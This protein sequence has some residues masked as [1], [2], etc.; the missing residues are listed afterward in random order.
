MPPRFA[1]VDCN[2]FY[3]SCERLF[4]PRLIGRPIIVLS[5]NDGCVIARSNE[6]KTVGIG[7]GQPFHECADLIR[8]HDIAVFSANFTL[9]GDL[10]HRVMQTLERFSPFIEVYSIDEAFLRLPDAIGPDPLPFARRLRQTVRRETG[11]PVSVGLGPTRLLAKLAN[12][13]AKRTPEREG[14]ADLTPPELRAATLVRTPTADLWGIGER[15]ARRLAAAGIRTAA[16]L[17]DADPDR[18]RKMFSIQEA[19]IVHELRGRPCI[20]VDDLS[21][22][23]QTLACSRS[24][25]ASVTTPDAIREAVVAYVSR[26]AEKLRGQ[27]SLAG[28][29]QVHIRTQPFRAADPQ[30]QAAASVRLPIPTDHTPTL[31]A[32]A[33]RAALLIFR[34]GY[35]YHKAGVLLYDLSPRDRRDTDLFTPLTPATDPRQ[36]GLMQAL[37]RLN[38][39]FGRHTVRVASAGWNQPWSMRQQYRSPAFTTRWADLP[40]VRADS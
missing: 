29:L 14:V 25:G 4:A 37:D 20:A 3:A 35:R 34:P 17:R 26:A 24:F 9:Y 5:N 1:L 22:P 18:I 2:N 33:G 30:Y 7:M 39:D 12:D 15:L 6:A 19:R 27:R 13:L 11:I 16:E 8:R 40:V 32:A 38:R 21:A 31:A 28:A 36:A 23:R 10:S